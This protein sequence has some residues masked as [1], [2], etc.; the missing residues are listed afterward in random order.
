MAKANYVTLTHVLKPEA[1]AFGPCERR[2]GGTYWE[3]MRDWAEKEVAGMVT[4]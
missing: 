4:K 2:W 1:S 3:K